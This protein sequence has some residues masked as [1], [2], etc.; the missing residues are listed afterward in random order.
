LNSAQKRQL[1]SLF[2]LVQLF[3]PGPVSIL[4]GEELGLL[5][6][7]SSGGAKQPSLVVFPWDA[8]T[9]A[10]R[11]DQFFLLPGDAGAQDDYAVSLI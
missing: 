4:Y 7:N 5:S 1:S 6:G 10:K 9:L 2:S 8:D 11:K 3:I